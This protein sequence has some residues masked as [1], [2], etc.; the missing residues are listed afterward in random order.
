MQALIERLEGRQFLS[1]TSPTASVDPTVTGISF[2]EV[3]NPTAVPSNAFVAVAI[4]LGSSG[5]PINVNTIY[6]PNVA[7][8][9]TAQGPS[10]GVPLQQ[11]LDGQGTEL[12]LE[13]DG[14]LLQP[15]TQYTV[16]VTSKVKDTN[17]NPVTPFSTTFKTNSSG[18]TPSPGVHFKQIN[19]TTSSGTHYT[20]VTMGP[21]G[22]LWASTLDGRIMAFPIDAAGNLG[23]PQVYTIVQANNG[24]SETITG[25]TFDPSS[26][27]ADPKIWVTESEAGLSGASD[28]TG[29]I[30]L[31]SGANLTSYQN[32]V[33]GLPR[34]IRDHMTNQST[35]GPDGALYVSQGANTAMGAPDAIWGYRSEHLLNAA[36]LRVDTKALL[37]RLAAGLGP[38]NVKTIDAGG[39]YNPYAAGALVTLYA[40]GVRNAY[41]ILWAS[42]G[43]LYA[44]TNGSA[45]GSPVLAPP[46]QP[47]LGIAVDDQTE[48]DWLFDVKPGKYY[49]HPDAAR[50]QYILNDGNLG[51]S[52]IPLYDPQYPLGTKPDPNY[53]KPIFTF[54]PDESPDGIIQYKGNA[55][56]GAL[57]GHLLITEYGAGDDI[58]DLTLTSNGSV[59][60][61]NIHKGTPGTTGMGDLLSLVENPTNGDI[62]VVSYENQTIYRLAVSPTATAG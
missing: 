39:P 2:G 62:F 47:Q 45:A 48:W 33:V 61:T 23:K 24:G 55:F 16:V 30:A 44:P 40:T 25:I 54:G 1:A 43:H 7:L 41:D 19:Q 51:S 15:N 13:P 5:A 53:Q 10:H 9:P 27:A 56:G 36:I 3:T 26:T 12:L 21:D 38:L 20:D 59:N 35:F 60:G 57:N 29:K 4:R 11:F 14:V 42:N 17:G 8:Y 18:P 31:V 32:V 37:A 52:T 50:G 34:S 58:V 6:I 28:F 46:G 22:R 49:G